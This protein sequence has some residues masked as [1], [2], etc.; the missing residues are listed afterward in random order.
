MKKLLAKICVPLAIILITTFLGVFPVACLTQVS[1][2]DR[3]KAFIENVLPVDLSR[4]RITLK[5]QIDDGL[6]HLLLYTLDSDE[7]T[8]R[9]V[10]QFKNN[11]VSYCRV[12]VDKGQVISDRQY[13]SLVDAAKSILEKYQTYTKI[14]SADMID[15]LD[16]VDATK[17]SSIMV[18]N[19]NFTK[20]T[21]IAY[22]IE[23]TTFN[24]AYTVNGVEYTK[25]GIEFQNGIFSCL[26]DTRGVYSIGDTTVNISREQA[27]AIAMKYVENYSYAMPDGSR[28]SN[29]NISKDQSTARLVAYPINSL[30]LRPYWHIELYLN[31]TY[32]GSV[33]GLT[34]YVWA[35]SGEVFHC[36]NI[37]Y[38]GADYSNADSL[39]PE[40]PDTSTLPSPT[41]DNTTTPA[42]INTIV[43]VAVAATVVA[44]A[45][46]ALFIKKRNK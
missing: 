7:S 12:D 33:H 31:Q 18:G 39:H 21:I 25:L 35:N 28:I 11:A 32:P 46:T 34:V 20:Y 3:S 29:F 27:I 43:I 42:D 22:G 17:D 16:N 4:Y 10:C 8:L 9:V 44:I 37:A 36:S 41:S 40:L 38:G 5:N 23:V 26:Y 6:T 13:V 1:I 24:W 14:D 30:V 2:Q 45:A 19:I 15:M